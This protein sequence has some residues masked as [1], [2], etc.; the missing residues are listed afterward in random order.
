M[1][2]AFRDSP[3]NYAHCARAA[4]VGV[5]TARKAWTKGW[6]NKP[7]F[8][9]ISIRK[10]LDQ[11]REAA[12]A[13]AMRR[14]QEAIEKEAKQ[15]EYA[16]K[17]AIDVLAEEAQATKILRGEAIGVGVMI[18]EVVKGAIPLARRLGAALEKE[19]L[20]PKEAARI[21]S[22]VTLMA[23]RGGEAIRLALQLERL[24]LGE[25]TDILS[26]GN[27]K[28]NELTDEDVRE[29][30]QALD[31]AVHHMAD[32]PPKLRIIEGGAAEPGDDEDQTEES[33]S[34]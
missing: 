24:R 7:D 1:V 26:I 8:P 21:L 11:E 2:A 29:G 13:E 30:L 14:M 6:K 17:Q 28:E 34:S 15:K 16:R 3:G 33:E 20:S 4:G 22:S 10:V 19:D 18:A 12:R 31:R 25:P 27:A 9:P 5:A 23:V 32:R